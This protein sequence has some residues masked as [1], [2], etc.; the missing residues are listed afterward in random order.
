MT[1]TKN[2]EEVLD[3][4]STLTDH[5]SLE[6][7]IHVI[8]YSLIERG[9]SHLPGSPEQLKIEDVPELLIKH[10]KLHGQDLATAIVQQ[11]LVMA[12]WLSRN[13]T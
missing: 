5:L 9:V 2:L 10:K 6:E 11:G 7:Y 8:G 1:S 3:S 4:I 13:K 12:M